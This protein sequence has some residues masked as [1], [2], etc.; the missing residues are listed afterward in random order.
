MVLVKDINKLNIFLAMKKEVMILLVVTVF[1][2]GCTKI[3]EFSSSTKL[4]VFASNGDSNVAI[5]TGDNFDDGDYTKNPSWGTK[6]ICSRDPTNPWCPNIIDGELYVHGNSLMTQSKQA[7]GDWSFELKDMDFSDGKKR[8][9]A[10]IYFILE[11]T[12]QNFPEISYS[13]IPIT[14]YHYYQ[15][16]NENKD[17]ATI[18]VKVTTAIGKDKTLFEEKVPASPKYAVKIT[19]SLDNKFKLQVNDNSFEFADD[20]K[21]TKCSNFFIRPITWDGGASLFRMDNIKLNMVE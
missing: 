8:I 20:S 15:I 5:F 2:V 7:Y 9:N 14:G 13:V 10:D 18:G 17:Y 16:W 19:R 4:D 21:I 11:K 3:N 6:Q 12:K 1:L